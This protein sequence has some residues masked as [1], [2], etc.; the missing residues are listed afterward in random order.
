MTLFSFDP[1]TGGKCELCN[2]VCFL[3][4]VERDPLTCYIIS[5]LI[6]ISFWFI[7]LAQDDYQL[8]RDC[9]SGY[10]HDSSPVIWVFDF[11][12]ILMF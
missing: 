7:F 9:I 12:Y 10:I 6:I 8:V 4:F 11:F 3:P 2:M 5:K 1:D